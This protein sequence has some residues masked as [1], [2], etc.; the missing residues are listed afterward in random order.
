[1]NIK[2]ALLLTFSLFVTKL[3]GQDNNDSTKNYSIH[4]GLYAP[5]VVQSGL[6]VGL[7]IPIK[8]WMSETKRQETRIHF[9]DITP[10]FG[11]FVESDVQRNYFLDATFE[12]RWLESDRKIH[13]K[14][15][16]GLG[17]MLSRQ[18]TSGTLDLS[19]GDIEFDT[20][21]LNFF[22]PTINIGFERNR[23]KFIGY[24]F[25]VFYGRKF[26][27]QEVNSDFIGAEFGATFNMARK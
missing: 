2:V 25:S 13:P 7:S 22:V 20:R 8:N 14:I 1:M 6:R 16:I 3:V 12:Y 27:G 21:S 24:Y 11:Y 15:G 10:R 17:Y 9:L 4:V 26:T 18:N 23:K 5:Y 19:S